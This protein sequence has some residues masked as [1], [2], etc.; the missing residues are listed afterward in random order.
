MRFLDVAVDNE[1][2]QLFST[3]SLLKRKVGVVRASRTL[4]SPGRPD[5][6]PVG[7]DASIFHDKAGAAAV[8]RLQKGRL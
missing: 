4:Q 1:G 5:H 6:A 8:A 2:N 7:R 3:T